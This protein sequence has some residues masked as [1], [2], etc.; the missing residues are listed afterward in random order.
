M[1]HTSRLRHI[2][3]SWLPWQAGPRLALADR[4]G[5]LSLAALALLGLS[6]SDLQRLAMILLL[7]AF[8]IAAWDLRHALLRSPLAWLIAAWLLYLTVRTVSTGL[9]YGWE[10]LDPYVDPDHYARGSALAAIL[11]GLWLRDDPLR[12]RW[13]LGLALAG[14]LLW[15]AL[16]T[17]WPAIQQL[18]PGRWVFG[19]NPNRVGLVMLITLLGL[20][21]VGLGWATSSTSLRPTLR[22]ILGGASVLGAIAAFWGIW[23]TGSR[24]ILVA[25]AVTLP[26]LTVLLVHRIGTDRQWKPWSMGLAL[27]ALFAALAVSLGLVGQVSDHASDRLEQRITSTV[28]TVQEFWEGDGE[29][30][31]RGSSSQRLFML[32]TGWEAAS[33]RPLLGHGPINPDRW[34]SPVGQPHWHN[35]FIQTTIAFG[36]IGA[37]LF[38]SGFI[39]IA[40]NYRRTARK[41]G[42]D[43]YVMLFTVTS[44]FALAVVLFFTI[45]I[46]QAVGRWVI[47]LVFGLMAAPLVARW[48][49]GTHTPQDQ[50]A[51]GATALRA[52][53]DAADHD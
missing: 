36:V 42:I 21:T 35:I 24:Q 46:D 26:V 1:E 34:L 52:G 40:S 19:D 49:P 45:R 17:D 15:L 33:E 13:L 18:S 23:V 32:T 53:R 10:A 4:L 11:A 5:F 2:V 38:L 29:V 31:T 39:Y 20:L 37:L 51:S 3:P 48:L 8:L 30:G 28:E 12:T 44:V 41:A 9:S 7:L 22:W 16:Y 27:V 14:V 25:C 50:P 43:P 47:T 6:F